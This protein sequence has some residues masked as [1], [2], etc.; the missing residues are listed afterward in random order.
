MNQIGQEGA[1][2]ISEA[3]KVNTSL[4]WLEMGS[5][6]SIREKM[7]NFHSNNISFFSENPARGAPLRDI[8]ATI[9]VSN[10]INHGYTSLGI[11]GD[12]WNKKKIFMDKMTIK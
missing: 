9:A 4:R 6:Y 11:A 3:V 1:I 12:A 8:Y 10:I 7:I 5:D 2:R